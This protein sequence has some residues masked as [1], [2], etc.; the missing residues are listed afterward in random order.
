[1]ALTLSFTPAIDGLTGPLGGRNLSTNQVDAIGQRAAGTLWPLRWAEPGAK[2]D[3]KGVDGWMGDTPVQLKT[4]TEIARSG[5]LYFE[6]HE[7]TK[8]QPGQPWRPS[9]V[10][11][12]TTYIF[13]SLGL[14]LRIPWAAYLQAKQGRSI[15]QVNETSQGYLIP[16][17]S[18]GE[19]DGFYGTLSPMIK[20][21]FQVNRLIPPEQAR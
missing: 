17:P 9:P 3:R 10:V 14:A 15:S 5:R 2:D 16:I 20:A 1:M 11:P 4:D 6:I 8:G 18:L 13:I 12:G 7:K 19:G 21:S